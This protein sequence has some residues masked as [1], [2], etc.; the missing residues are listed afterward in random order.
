MSKFQGS[1][2]VL[3]LGDKF[4]DPV[5]PADFN[6]VGV[7]Y[8]DADLSNRIGLDLSPEQVVSHF[9]RF[10]PLDGSLSQPLALRYHGP[11]SYTHLTLP[12]IYSV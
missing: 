8:F 12:T 9:L 7:R 3:A 10:E 2:A 4:F 11:V 1:K 6:I 5:R